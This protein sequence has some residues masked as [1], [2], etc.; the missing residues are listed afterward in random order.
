M[1]P[2][3]FD[4]RRQ[5]LERLITKAEQRVAELTSTPNDSPL[6]KR[7]RTLAARTLARHRQ[8]L[9]NLLDLHGAAFGI[10]SCD[11]ASDRMEGPQ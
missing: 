9:K 6:G 11:K 4:A 3:H 1:L 7:L 5:R 2:H 10:G 8:S